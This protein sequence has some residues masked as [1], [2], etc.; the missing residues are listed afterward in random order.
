MMVKSA[1]PTTAAGRVLPA[2]L[3]I[4]AEILAYRTYVVRWVLRLRRLE[5]VNDEWMDWSEQV[6]DIGD[7]KAGR[8]EVL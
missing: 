2:S 7:W 5:R 4:S 8:E 6:P 3:S 1:E